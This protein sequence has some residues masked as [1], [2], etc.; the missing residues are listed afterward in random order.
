MKRNIVT[1]VLAS[2]MTMISLSASANTYSFKADGVYYNMISET[3]VGVTAG[4]D[5]NAYSGNVVIPSEVTFN[6]NTYKVVSIEENAFAECSTLV[7]VVIPSTVES[8]G[9]SAFS[10]CVSLKSVSLPNSVKSLGE[11]SFWNC[12]SLETVELPQTLNDICDGAFFGC[13]SLS[14]LSIPSSVKKIG[15]CAFYKCTSLEKIVI[16]SSVSII[17]AGAFE[18]CSSLALAVDCS[19]IAPMLGE[20]AFFNIKSDASF[21]VAGEDAT[22][23]INEG[24]KGFFKNVVASNPI[25]IVKE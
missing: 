18:N 4:S 5:E 21:C 16:P 7:S 11:Y 1:M 20:D 9:E 24:Y 14:T 15:A 13:T 12:S 23:Y 6:N 19:E 25:K 2:V 3:T 17:S 8:V 22:S 10:D